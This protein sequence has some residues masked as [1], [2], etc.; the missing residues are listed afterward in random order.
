MKSPKAQVITTEQAQ[1]MAKLQSLV[2][3]AKKLL[4]EAEEI[5]EKLQGEESLQRI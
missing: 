4:K 1:A 3:L 2:K 5:K